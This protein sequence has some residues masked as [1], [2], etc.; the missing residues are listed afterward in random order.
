MS[1]RTPYPPGMLFIMPC[2]SCCSPVWLFATPWTVAC[3][4]P[5]SMEFSRQEYWS[6]L[7]FPSPGDLPNP[8]IEPRSP[9]LQA[10]S[11]PSKPASPIKYGER[12][13]I[14]RTKMPLYFQTQPLLPDS[15]TCLYTGWQHTHT[16]ASLTWQMGRERWTEWAIRERI[17]QRQGRRVGPDFVVKPGDGVRRLI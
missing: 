2:V 3:Q 6:A 17:S 12:N 9:V 14:N 7:P 1:I 4:A 15:E 8:G 11:L 16:C 10:D 13:Q 5:L